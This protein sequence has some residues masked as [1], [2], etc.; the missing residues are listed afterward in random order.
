M[1][2]TA[3]HARSATS[4]EPTALLSFRRLREPALY[5]LGL[6]P[7]LYYGWQLW[8]AWRGEPH[9]LGS[10]P[11]RAVQLATGLWALRF[12]LATLAVTPL[13]R[14]LGWNAL[15]PYRRPL[16]LL[17]FS[18]ALLHFAN[19]LVVDNWFDWP[20]IADDI[21]KRPWITIGTLALVVLVPLALTSTTASIRRLGGRRWRRL[22]RLVYLAAIAGAIHFLLSVKR[23]VREPLVYAAILGVLFVARTPARRR[24]ARRTAPPRDARLEA[25]G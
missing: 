22:H 16:G 11:I 12:L 2:L 1:V 6:V 5:A 24:A 10:D 9:V 15:A 4:R 21:V 18:Y 7:A 8:R 17:A 19:Y 23:D 14:W 20:T 25:T 13:R 3:R